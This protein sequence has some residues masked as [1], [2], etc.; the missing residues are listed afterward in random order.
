LYLSVRVRL[1]SSG[2]HSLINNQWISEPGYTDTTGDKNATKEVHETAAIVT[3]TLAPILFSTNDKLR[4]A[5]K[6]MR[7]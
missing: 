4:R 7:I 3:L 5:S 2:H 6:P 1:C